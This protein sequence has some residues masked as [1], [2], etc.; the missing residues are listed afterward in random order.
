MTSLDYT[1]KEYLGLESNETAL[2]LT[3]QHKEQCNAE[4]RDVDDEKQLKWKWDFKISCRER[5]VEAIWKIIVYNRIKRCF[6][7]HALILNRLKAS[8]SK[9]C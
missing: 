8:F 7:F 5:L 3:L 4:F 2:D 6:Y 9:C 1:W